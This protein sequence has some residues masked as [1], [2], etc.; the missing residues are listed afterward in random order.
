MQNTENTIKKR[1]IFGWAMFDFANS[2]YTT[3]ILT[4]I[5]NTYFVS[6]IAGDIEP[7]TATFLWTITIAIAN[8]IVLFSS[9]LIG[10][11]SDASCNKKQFLFVSTLLC[12]LFTALLFFTGSGDIL[13]ACI[14]IIISSLMFFI[15]ESLISAFLP[16]ISTQKNIGKISGYGWALGYFGG[17]AALVLCLL[18]VNYAKAQG[19]SADQFI[20]VT[21]L[22]VAFFFGLS[23][24]PTFL[25]LKE[26]CNK[27]KKH[28]SGSTIKQGYRQLIKTWQRS[29]Q[30]QDFFRFLICLFVYHCG[31]NTVVVIAAIYAQQVMHFTTEDTILLIIIVNISAAAGAFSFGVIQDKLGA[32]KTLSLTLVIWITAMLIA[33]FTSSITWFWLVA[34]LIGVALGSSQSAGRSLVG[35]FSPKNQNGEFFGL[36]GLAVRLAA[37]VGPMSYGLIT[38]LTQGDHRLALLSTTLFFIVGLILLARV[39]EDKGRKAAIH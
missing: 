3:V 30:Y 19:D 32:K 25:L 2:G 21:M 36:W 13:L 5:F 17:L 35:L 31:I 39:N 22:I 29:H 9:P 4:A 16:E 37:I 34:N 12:T 6:V 18:Y 33:F 11:I 26:R 38:Y 15:G 28:F 20:P 14:L 1:E 27:K 23:S 10:A 24:L 7:G 8:A